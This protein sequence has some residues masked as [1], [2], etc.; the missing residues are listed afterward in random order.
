MAGGAL[1]SMLA[2]GFDPDGI[3]ALVTLL[4]VTAARPLGYVLLIPLLGRFHLNTGYLRG[5][6]LVALILPVMPAAIAAA[7]A[8][9]TLL[10]PARVPGLM[11]TEFL[12]GAILG[13]LAGL[14][15]WAAQ[16]AGDFM[17]IQRG[18]QMAQILDPGSA[19]Q[20]SVTGTLLLLVCILVLAAKGLLVPALFG[21]VLDSYG[22]V[23][24]FS[25]LPRIEPAQGALA[26]RL[27]D[28]L[29]RT[30][31]VLALPVLVPL[32]L[33]E[34]AVAVATK[35]MPQLNAMFLSMAIKQA[36]QA[37]LMIL[38][39]AVLAGYAIRMGASE[40]LRPQALDAFLSGAA[41]P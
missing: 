5:A 21:P 32:L 9:P 39:A 37:L 3:R 1:Q 15:L 10:S 41:R 18:A 36:V 40:D 30:G 11:A 14:P 20:Q 31:L 16:A 6:L 23:P 38:Y 19:D 17:D 35:Y 12:V 27:L 7:D 8:D 22:V 26:L 33:V 13:L 34:M 24:L 25:P 28:T 29:T 2:M 4:P